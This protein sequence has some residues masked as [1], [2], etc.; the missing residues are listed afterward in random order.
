M[1]QESEAL[2][3]SQTWSI[4]D[5][6]LGCKPINCKWVYKV[7]YNSDES[8]ERYKARLVIRGDKQI[9][10]VEYNETFAPVAKMA[11]VHCF[12][13]ITAAKGWTLHQMDVNNAFLHG[14]L[15]EEVYMT[16]LLDSKL[17][18]LPKFVVFRNPCMA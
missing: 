12:L 16:F 1:A 18:A 3:L 5:L 13:S 8:I 17:Q 15:Y 7:K 10:G 6:P 9:E 2:E 11:S 14:D 4:V